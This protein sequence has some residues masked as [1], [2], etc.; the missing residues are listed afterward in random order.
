MFKE[1]YK[2]RAIQQKI[3][4]AKELLL[5]M[6]RKQTNLCVAADVTTKNELLALADTLG[7]YICV[8]KVTPP[9]NS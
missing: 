1:S 8:F 7:P 3:P 5:L 6:D 2:T 9:S 4:L